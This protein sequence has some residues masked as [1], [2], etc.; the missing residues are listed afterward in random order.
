M[1]TD[2]LYSY[3][4]NFQRKSEVIPPIGGAIGDDVFRRTNY[5]M[6]CYLLKLLGSNKDIENQFAKHDLE[7]LCLIA[8]FLDTM[9]PLANDPEL[10][11]TVKRAVF[12]RLVESTEQ[13]LAMRKW[14]PP[15]D[16]HDFRSRVTHLTK[17]INQQTS[18]WEL[19]TMH[20][21]ADAMTF[22]L[23]DY[24]LSAMD[25]PGM[26]HAYQAYVM[27]G[28]E[29]EIP[30]D[31]RSKARAFVLRFEKYI[32]KDRVKPRTQAQWNASLK[33]WVY[34]QYTK[35]ALANSIFH[36][37]SFVLQILRAD[38]YEGPGPELGINE[39]EGSDEWWQAI[40]DRAAE[41]F[42]LPSLIKPMDA[43][44]TDWNTKNLKGLLFQVAHE[45]WK[46]QKGKEKARAVL[47][48]IPLK[49][50][51]FPDV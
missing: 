45:N 25:P 19:A 4:H 18:I 13:F 34:K 3:D 36:G 1:F 10:L 15:K 43:I 6:R 31:V 37:K 47:R 49:A 12:A 40:Q 22:N 42:Q 28:I 39:E 23:N 11:K 51:Y 7:G 27:L 24:V 14:W 41:E 8:V 38:T 9:L 46:A 29:E 5:C 50:T 26:F 17:M 35:N 48:K 32:F 2:W 33:N 30:E 20:T 44:M 21:Y 16:D